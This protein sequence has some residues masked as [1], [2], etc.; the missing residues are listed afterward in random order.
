MATKE[1]ENVIVVNDDALNRLITAAL[2]VVGS[3]SKDVHSRCQRAVDA[4]LGT[5]SPKITPHSLAK[6]RAA[7]E[8][9]NPGITAKVVR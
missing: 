1:D 9:I 6:L 7:L 5:S 8:A 3:C 2:D 4:G